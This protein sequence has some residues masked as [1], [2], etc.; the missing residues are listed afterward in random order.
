MFQIKVPEFC[1]TCILFYVT[2]ACIISVFLQQKKKYELQI[3]RHVL[4][5]RCIHCDSAYL[6]GIHIYLLLVMQI[7]YLDI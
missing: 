6:T 7:L 3:E 1:D 2:I 5:Y 4:F